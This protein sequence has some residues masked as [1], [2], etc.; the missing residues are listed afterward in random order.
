LSNPAELIVFVLVQKLRS[1]EY[2]RR[3]KQ[4]L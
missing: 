4:D 3:P 1:F 2:C